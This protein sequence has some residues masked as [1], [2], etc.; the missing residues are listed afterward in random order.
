MSVG[1]VLLLFHKVWY[2]DSFYEVKSRKAIVYKF[3]VLETLMTMLNNSPRK[4]TTVI[5]HSEPCFFPR[6]GLTPTPCLLW[7]WTL[8]NRRVRVPRLSYTS[9]I[10]THDLYRL[11]LPFQCLFEES[12]V[13]IPGE[14]VSQR[15]LVSLCGETVQRP[16]TSTNLS[17][18]T[19]RILDLRR[20]GWLSIQTR[21]YRR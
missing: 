19:R 5:T 20:S 4:F 10:K 12:R 3:I 17:T 6:Q 14:V 11:G 21:P 18:D 1:D 16:K 2:T 9:S 8:Y 15:L 13:L 7:R